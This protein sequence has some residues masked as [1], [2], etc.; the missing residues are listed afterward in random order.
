MRVVGGEGTAWQ[1]YWQG[2]VCEESGVIGNVC[3]REF[4]GER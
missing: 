4:S 2:C 3:G 1:L